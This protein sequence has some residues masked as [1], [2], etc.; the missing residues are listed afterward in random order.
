MVC[1]MFIWATQYCVLIFHVHWDEICL[2]FIISNMQNLLSTFFPENVAST[3]YLITTCLFCGMANLCNIIEAVIQLPQ[4]N[5]RGCHI[6][7]CIICFVARKTVL[8]N[9]D[10]GWPSSVTKPRLCYHR[11]LNKI[12][13]SFKCLKFALHSVLA[14]PVHWDASSLV[15]L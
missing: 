7:I 3:H 4:F 12:T 1:D 15:I 9:I 2:I 10:P 13:F 6:S 11:Q 5:P 14:T 8:E